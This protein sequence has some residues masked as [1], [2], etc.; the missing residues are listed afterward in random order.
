MTIS[1]TSTAQTIASIEPYENGQARS[2][3]ATSPC[4]IFTVCFDSFPRHPSHYSKQPES[5]TAS[6]AAGHHNSTATCQQLQ[7]LAPA[8]FESRPHALLEANRS[9]LR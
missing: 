2:E 1:R 4:M 5:N 7:S 9:T 8:H 6:A 3:P